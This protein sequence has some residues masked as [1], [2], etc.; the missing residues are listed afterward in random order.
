MKCYDFCITG[1]LGFIAKNLVD[2]LI[3]DNQSVCIIDKKTYAADLDAYKKFKEL[4]IDIIEE[5]IEDLKSLP[6]CRVLINFAASSHVDNSIKAADDTMKSNY[7]GVYNL[8]NLIKDL[9]ESDRPLF[10]QVSTDEV[11]GSIREGCFNEDNKFNPSNPY[12][13]SKAAAELLINAYNK[14]F[15]IEYLISR[16]CNNYGIK[17]YPEKLI[18]RAIY[19]K[20]NKLEFPVHGNGTYV[21]QWIHA[22]DHVSGIYLLIKD[23]LINKEKYKLDKVFNISGETY[24]TNNQVLDIIDSCD[25][26]NPLK[27]KPIK[28]RPGQDDRYSID[29]SKIKKFVDWKEEYPLTLESL[30]DIYF[31]EGEF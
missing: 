1:G 11:F 26:K 19:C 27:R 25:P 28:N 14:T 12:S 9:D 24:L 16:S 18:P 5:G 31:S 30:K 15:D 8:L 22:K 13:A 6:R 7:M 3:K 2:L 17:Q 20:K 10:H 4:D 29:S 23:Y 21:R